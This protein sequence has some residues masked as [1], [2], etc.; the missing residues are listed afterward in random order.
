RVS[1]ADSQRLSGAQVDDKTCLPSF[2]E[3]RAP[4]GRCAKEHFIWSEWQFERAIRSKVVR[5]V[6]RIQRVI[7]VAIRGVSKTCRSQ[8]AGARE[9]QSLGPNV[10][11]L[12]T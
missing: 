11:T 12:K 2:D 7:F 4:S 5:H 3:A 6:V 10:R 1:G 9:F 8:I